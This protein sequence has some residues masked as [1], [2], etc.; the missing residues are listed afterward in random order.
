MEE[1]EKRKKRLKAIREEAAEA[2]DSTEEQNSIGLTNPLI[3]TPSG[4]SG[5]DEPRPR[6]DYYTDPMAAF[7]ANNKK[8]NL[9]PQVSQPCNTP[10]RPMNAGSPAHHA[11]GNYNSAHRTDGFPQGGGA[12]SQYGQGN[13]YQGLGSRARPYRGSRRGGGQF[14]FYYHKSMV[15]DPWKAFK[16]VIWKPRG[17]TRDSLKSWHPNSISTKKAKLGETPTKSTPQQ[18]LA[19]YLAAAFNEA[20]GK[21]AVNNEPGTSSFDA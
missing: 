16:P 19:E 20:A 1:S 14:K 13:P 5:Q 2:A 7:S 12:G 18:G 15:E 8:N 10:P 4:S 6:F 3:D 11:Q 21:D 9:G 17:D